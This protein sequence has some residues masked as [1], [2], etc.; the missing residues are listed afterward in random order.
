MGSPSEPHHAGAPSLGGS[1]C[2]P[3]RKKPRHLT[4]A[5]PGEILARVPSCASPRL[6]R[7]RVPDPSSSLFTVAAGTMHGWANTR[8]RI[9]S[10]R[11]RNFGVASAAQF[12]KLVL[13]VA[14]DVLR[15][16]R[17]SSVDQAPSLRPHALSGHKKPHLFDNSHM[18]DT[19]QFQVAFELVPRMRRCWS[20]Y[21][22]WR[23]R[24]QAQSTCERMS[25]R[26][27]VTPTTSAACSNI[28]IAL[29]QSRVRICYSSPPL[30]S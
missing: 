11:Y 28:A 10:P 25:S 22:T 15:P 21:E 4:E 7:W 13:F 27:A 18:G 2:T 3:G 8:L 26:K 30:R 23:H 5:L 20:N 16:W 24:C 9:C 17:Q 19:V 14:A 1:R 29:L 12:K 6:G